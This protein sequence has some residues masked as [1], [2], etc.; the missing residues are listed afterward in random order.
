MD[1]GADAS[2]A[3]QGDVVSNDAFSS[4]ADSGDG[5]LCPLAPCGA[6][7]DMSGWPATGQSD[8]LPPGYDQSELVAAV[9]QATDRAVQN[10]KQQAAF[11]DTGYGCLTTPDTSGEFSGQLTENDLFVTT[12]GP[13]ASGIVTAVAEGS[14]LCTCSEAP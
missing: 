3:T 13:D 8:P 9:Q 2:D 1:S 10:L 5:G 12:S 7:V 14:F 6:V 11:T 4:D